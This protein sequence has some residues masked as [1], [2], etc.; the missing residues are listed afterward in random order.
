MKRIISIIIISIAA[1]SI[2]LLTALTVLYFWAASDLPSIKKI[3]DYN[4]PVATTVYTQHNKILGY[5][6][7]EKRFLCQLKE[8]SPWIPKAFIAAEDESFYQHPGFDFFSIIR[9]AIANLKA[10]KI[11]QGGSTITQQVIDTLLIDTGKSYFLK[12]KEAILAY[13]LDKHLSKEEI[14]TIYLNQIYLGEGAYGIEAAARTYFAKHASELSLSEAALIAGLP[15]AP[16]LYNPYENP[17]AAKSRQ[18]YVLRRM[19][20]TG[21][22]NQKRYKQALE[23]KLN[24]HKMTDPSWEKGAYYLQTVRNELINKY[25]RKKVYRGG[26]HVYSAIDLK[27]QKAAQKALRIGLEDLSKRRGW[28]GPIKNLSEK[29]YKAFLEKENIDYEKIK[30]GKWIKVLVTNVNKKGAFVCFEQKKGFISVKTMSWARKLNPRLAPGAV[31]DIQNARKVLDK[32][33]VIYASVKEKP[34]QDSQIWQLSLEQKPKVE[35][36]VFSFDP[37]TGR[38]KAIVGGYSFFRSQYNRAIQAKRQPGSAFKPIVYSAALEQGHTATSPLIDA[39][40]VK[41]N[42]RSNISWKPRNYSLQVRG[43][44][45]FRTGLVHSINLATI[46]LAQDI[47]IDNIIEQAKSL[48]L[49]GPFPHD[50]T[51]SIGS[52]SVSL[53]NL[54]QAYSAFARDGS[55][56]KPCLIKRITD[57][58]GTEIFNNHKQTKRAITPQN[59]YIITKLLQQV[60]QDGTGWR[61]KKLGR[62]VAGKTGTTNK[63][64]DAWFIGYTPYLLTGI[65]VGFNQPRTLGKYET[66]SRAASPI[67]LNYRQQIENNYPVQQ[68]IAPSGIIMARIDSRTGLLASPKCKNTYLLPFRKGRQP[69]KVSESKDTDTG[70]NEL[71]KIF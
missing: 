8:M 64:R 41:Q 63:Q 55:I 25:G 22:I 42:Q 54:C 46:R 9:A 52:L 70:S 27:H 14:L 26:L 21:K 32:G 16:S 51:I 13:R 3:T 36:A 17:L 35:G 18:K 60:V 67:W 11:V 62:P 30:K 47:G 65:Y 59:T 5:F 1:I 23:A 69:Q 2:F 6:F 29:Q 33:D 34:G 58:W 19:L 45:L 66:G 44:I 57:S 24:Y 71:K 12:L 48:G 40:V 37:R 31:P 50:L 39:P 28:R 49:E 53:I 56:I 20:T 15:K 10:G 43:K 4:P 68:F 38:V 7:K 61:V